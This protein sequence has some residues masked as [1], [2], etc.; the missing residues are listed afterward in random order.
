M[1]I[2]AWSEHFYTCGGALAA[3]PDLAVW[4]MVVTKL[5]VVGWPL[6]LYIWCMHWHQQGKAFNGVAGTAGWCH[7]LCGWLLEH[8][9][10]TASIFVLISR[11]LQLWCIAKKACWCSSTQGVCAI[12]QPC[13]SFTHHHQS[14]NHCMVF[15]SL[16]L[17]APAACD[18]LLCQNAHWLP[19][20]GVQWPD[21]PGI[22][23]AQ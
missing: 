15:C 19:T 4:K 22:P 5:A 11:V 12:M 8:A 1:P 13:H 10:M 14:N 6:L 16:S 23:G 18:T 21:V 17:S 7:A 3:Y 20:P 9:G 2:M